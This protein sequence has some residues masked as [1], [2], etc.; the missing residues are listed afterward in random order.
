MKTK[1]QAVLGVF[2]VAIIAAC[3]MS[4]EA[5]AFRFADFGEGLDEGVFL[6]VDGQAITGNGVFAFGTISNFQV[7]Q[8]FSTLGERMTFDYSFGTTSG[9]GIVYTVLE[10]GFGEDR[11]Y[12]ISDEF[13]LYSGTD[14][15]FHVDFMS[16]DSIER[17]LMADFHRD[18]TLPA[19]TRL[20]E[21][22]RYQL[23]GSIVDTT[24]GEVQHTFE[25][26]SAV[27]EPASM[28]LLGLGLAG[29]GARRWR[30]R[31]AS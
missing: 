2:G 16:I 22:P 8:F 20:P 21:L 1:L 24:T 9:A 5:A 14:G 29:M 26:Q 7:N 23:V 19:P 18:L 30:Q 17:G 13:L 12:R 15:V 11:P 3:P 10:G 31:K 27:P 6:F 28:T 4:A 25:V